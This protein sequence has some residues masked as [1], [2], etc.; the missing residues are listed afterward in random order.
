[1]QIISL[2]GLRQLSKKL[3][4]KGYP[5]KLITFFIKILRISA[6]FSKLFILL[7][8]WFIL[9]IPLFKIC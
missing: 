8:N 3:A 7:Q 9:L 1:M 6:E 2:G 5:K 4:Y